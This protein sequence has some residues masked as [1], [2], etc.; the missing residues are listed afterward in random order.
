MVAAVDHVVHDPPPA[1]TLVDRIGDGRAVPKL[2]AEP[3]SEFLRSLQTSKVLQPRPVRTAPP[4]LDPGSALDRRR[5]SDGPVKPA[6]REEVED[7]HLEA[8][9][10]VPRHSRHGDPL[11]LEGLLVQETESGLGR[12]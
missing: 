12:L 5:P 3:A 6:L 4:P 1:A 7:L 9:G 11:T 8:V 2:F 10:L